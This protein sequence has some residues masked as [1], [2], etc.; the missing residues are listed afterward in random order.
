MQHDLTNHVLAL[1]RD[2][3]WHQPARLSE[4]TEARYRQAEIE[5]Q[6]I[7]AGY[8]KAAWALR[9]VKGTVA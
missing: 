7:D 5:A 4:L 6:L 8:Q 9:A 2:L 3:K 1:L